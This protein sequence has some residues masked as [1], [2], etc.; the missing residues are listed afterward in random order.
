[1]PAKKGA[2]YNLGNNIISEKQQNQNLHH[3]TID[4]TENTIQNYPK[5]KELKNETHS[6][7]K[8][9]S[10]KFEPDVGTKRQEYLNKCCNY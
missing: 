9:K 5:D 10:I 3:L 6:L 7:E 2:I 4:N 1:M 8:R